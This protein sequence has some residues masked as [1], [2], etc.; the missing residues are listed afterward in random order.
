MTKV[1]FIAK[2][3]LNTDGRILNQIKI[4]EQSLPE[5][6]ID[7]ILLPDKPVIIN[8]GKNVK[9]HPI[10]TLIR[11][12]KYLRFLTTMEFIVKSLFLLLKLKP[13]I[14]H[15]QDSAVVM[16]VLIYRLIKGKSFNLIYDD[17]EIPNENEPFT[18]RIFHYFENVLMK[19]SD[20]VIFANKER[21]DILKSKNNL[22]NQNS[23]FLNL[24]YFENETIASYD[25]ENEN[26]L[27]ELDK[28]INEDYKFVIHQGPLNKERGREKLAEFSKIVPPTIKILLLGGNK[29]DFDSFINEYRLEIKNFHFIGSVNYL[30]LPRFWERAIASIVM[31]LPTYINNRL[32]APNRFYISLQKHLPVIVNKDNPVLSNFIKEYNCGV[33]IEDITQENIN[34]KIDLKID[35]G[36]FASL[37]SQQ[38]KSFVDVYKTL[39]NGIN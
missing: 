33:Y 13:E 36:F 6:K 32:C 10:N 8:P 22:N 7:F 29:K 14:V 25:K 5:I 16:P 35:S 20:H 21:M 18:S 31:Y 3:D 34:D 23:Y 24:P 1:V 37:K 38:I 39:E 17:H 28:L 9:V 19:K 12:N 27:L 15:A 4:L 2:T 11:H 30:I 26:K